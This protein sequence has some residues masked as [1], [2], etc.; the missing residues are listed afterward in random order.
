MSAESLTLLIG[1]LG[2]FL[3]V[4]G[5]GGKWLL[6]HLDAKDTASALRESEARD[7]LNSRLQQEISSLRAELL[8][9]KQERAAELLTLKQEQAAE[10]ALYRRR[11]YQLE[12]FIHQQP[13]LVMPIMDGWPPV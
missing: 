4:I 6:A 3:L 13:G 9:L 12:S 10:L 2:S 8:S 11:I 7:E 5:G 1:S